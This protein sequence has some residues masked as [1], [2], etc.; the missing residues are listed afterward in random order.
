MLTVP[1]LETGLVTD[2]LGTLFNWCKN[3][4]NKKKKKKNLK[5]KKKKKKKKKL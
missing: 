1:K 4:Y 3:S 5:I 2:H